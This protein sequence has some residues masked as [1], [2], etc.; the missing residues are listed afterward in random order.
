M[1][2]KHITPVLR[3]KHP[4]ELTSSFF[5]ADGTKMV[6]T[7]IDNKIR[8]FNTKQ[9][10]SDATSK[11]KVLKIFMIMLYKL[12][13]FTN[14]KKLRQHVLEETTCLFYTKIFDE[15]NFNVTDF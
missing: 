10:D 14:I 13:K 7:C 15:S 12:Y 8:I 11:L 3:F 5:S 9:F 4:K 2:N 6:S 1:T